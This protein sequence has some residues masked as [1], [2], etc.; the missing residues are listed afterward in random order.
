MIVY[1]HSEQGKRDYQQDRY[2]VFENLF[3]VADGMGGHS[4][5]EMA[6]QSVIDAYANYVG[7][8]EHAGESI[9]NFDLVAPIWEANH[10]CV[11][12][13]DDRGSTATAAIIKDGWLRVAHA[14]D[15]RVSIITDGIIRGITT[16]H[17]TGHKLNNGV[18]FLSHVDSFKTPVKSGDIVILSTDGV[19]DYLGGDGMVK[20][21]EDAFKYAEKNPED[22][23][24]N[25]AEHLVW[26]ALG[27][28]SWDN[29]TAIVVVV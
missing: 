9:D 25:L 10:E 12:S 1:A 17:G 24:W 7:Y 2:I 28:P 21:L 19:H 8:S 29:C 3:V 11:S 15:S 26:R 6:A 27:V 18:G 5:G 23:L 13:G 4:N 22:K 20:A 16:D 14:G